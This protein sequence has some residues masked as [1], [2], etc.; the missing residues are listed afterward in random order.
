MIKTQDSLDHEACSEPQSCNRRLFFPQWLT[1]K[2]F[3]W[4][5]ISK[6]KVAAANQI[7]LNRAKQFINFLPTVKNFCWSDKQLF[8]I[9][10]CSKLLF[11]FLLSSVDF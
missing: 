1:R 11:R 9:D 8:L 7:K 10:L 5:H 3:M 6:D 2:H 4:T